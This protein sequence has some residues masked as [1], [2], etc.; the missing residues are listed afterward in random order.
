[1]QTLVFIRLRLIVFKLSSL[2]LVAFACLSCAIEWP[3]AIGFWPR[4]NSQLLHLILPEARQSTSCP[5]VGHHD[6]SGHDILKF[7]PALIR[8]G[9]AKFR[10]ASE[11]CI[12]CSRA[13]HF[14][15]QV[16]AQ[17]IGCLLGD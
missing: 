12:C 11:V 6:L 4:L 17:N 16:A 3:V 8:D 7:V 2:H 10:H 1:M 13:S 5:L 14:S 15:L 9:R